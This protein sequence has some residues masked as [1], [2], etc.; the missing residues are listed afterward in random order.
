M[1]TRNQ[2]QHNSSFEQNTK[3]YKRKLSLSRTA[4]QSFVVHMTI[5]SSGQHKGP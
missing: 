3:D 5:S 1:K 4:L 2:G